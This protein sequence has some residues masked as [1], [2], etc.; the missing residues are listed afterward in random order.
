MPLFRSQRGIGRGEIAESRVEAPIFAAFMFV[1][2]VGL[3]LQ[4]WYVGNASITI[5]LAVSLVVFG[6][7]V[8]RVDFGVYILVVAMLL[9]PEI[10]MGNSLSGERSLNLR[11]DDILI[12]VIFLGVMTRLSFEGRLS[13][14]QPS[15]INAGI[16]AYYG[17]CLVSTLLAYERGLGA[18]NERT[19]FFVMLK[20]LEFYMVFWLVGHAVRNLDDMRNQ[21]YLF[22]VVAIIVSAYAI[23]TI[24]TEPRVSAPFEKGGTEPN[25]LGGYLVV[26]MCAAIG[27]LSQAPRFAQKLPFI[28]VTAICS[29]PLLYTLSRASYVAM[30]V[31]L[32]ILTLITRR[33]YLFAALALLAVSA[34]FIMPTEVKE[35]VAYTF[36][37]VGGQEVNV[38]GR[39]E[40]IRVDKSTYERI[41]V[42]RKVWYLMRLGLQFCLFGG[43]VSWESVLD[44]QYARVLME[45]GV[46]GLIAFVFLQSRVLLNTRQAY[47][48]TPDWRGRGLAMGMFAATL[49]LMVHSAGTISFLIVRIMEPFWYLVALT[50]LVRQHALAYHKA[51]AQQ[52]QAPQPETQEATPPSEGKPRPRPARVRTP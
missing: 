49:A 12:I 33:A 32:V 7:T 9:S 24:G 2:S 29:V 23:Y 14:W 6:T 48:W 34:P 4:H 31:G 38:V 26:V 37:E 1:C 17:V 41:L 44:S 18:W 10:E 11:Y 22:F 21:L 52:Q 30:I 5:A 42:W 27:L 51:R 50:V 19:A 36:Q 15:P 20:M 8:I 35:R 46:L 13:L 25:T 28:I 47:R 39:D 3:L 16:V 43:G 40:P 45:T